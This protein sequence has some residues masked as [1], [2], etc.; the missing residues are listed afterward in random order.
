MAVDE[1]TL[2]QAEESFKSSLE[3][4][5]TVVSKLAPFCS[6]FEELQGMIKEGLS[7]PAQARLLMSIVATPAQ[8]H[9]RR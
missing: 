5:F 3:D 9:G 6:T 4:S 1:K 2:A 8:Q 7:N